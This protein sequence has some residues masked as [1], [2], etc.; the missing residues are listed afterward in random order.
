[1]KEMP[2][3]TKSFMWMFILITQ[4]II[5][6]YQKEK[7]SFLRHKS[8][9]GSESPEGPLRVLFRFHSDRVLFRFFSDIVLLRI[10]SDRVLFVSSIIDSSLVLS[11][12]F[13]RHATI[14]YQNVL[15]LFLLKACPVFHYIFKRN[16][17]LYN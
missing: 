12:L 1:M 6:Q 8:R 3:K 5:Y 7:K 9:E 11:V 4:S 13:L 14:F 15:L 2:F 16:F 10:L 17:T